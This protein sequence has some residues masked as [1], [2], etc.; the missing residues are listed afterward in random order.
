MTRTPAFLSFLFI[1][2]QTLF[3]QTAA[4]PVA[5][6]IAQ[7]DLFES[8][9]KYDLALDAYHKADKLAHHQSANCFLKMASVERRLGDFPEALNDT[10][11]AIAAA[12]NDKE[13]AVRAYMMRAILLVGMSGKPTDK[14]LKEAEEDTRQAI[15]LGP[16]RAMAHFNLG[17]ILLK[18][19]RDSDGVAELNQALGLDFPEAT[20]VEAR[21]YIAS[22]VRAREPF[23]PDFNFMTKENQAY[24]NSSLRG[25]VVLFDFWATWCP[26]CRES[27]PTIKNV[28]KK[29]ASK[30][31]VLVGIS[32]D[33]DEDVWRTFI[34]S[35][36]MDWQEYIDLAGNLN[37]AFKIESI[38]TYIVIDKDGVIRFRQSGFGSET[39]GELDDAISK[40]LKRE[41]NPALAKAA[42]VEAAPQKEES[43]SSFATRV[44][45]SDARKDEAGGNA[46]GKDSAG[47][48]EDR[49]FGIEAGTVS[50]N[51]YKNDAL[52]MTYGFPSGWTAATSEKLHSSN[53]K[54]EASLMQQ[55]PE[56]ANTAILMPKNIFYA[57]KKGD[58]DATRLSVPCM[59]ISATP[60]RLDSI[61]LDR[62]QKMAEN[63]A[64]ASSGKL[65]QP[66]NEFT[67]KEHSFARADIERMAGGMHLYQSYVQTLAGDYLLTIEIY[68]T[69]ADE[70]RKAA[71]TLETMVIRDE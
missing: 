5:Q 14:K 58:G 57:S 59:R 61:S 28:K 60:S 69:S 20:A 8:K 26:P 46:G 16:K 52:D 37:E 11:K 55:H 51:R 71:T 38:P 45:E 22:P 1:F 19:E 47:N 6:A 66:A 17:T 70:L 63:M 53:V 2:A 24:N 67:V 30:G 56:L 65:L 29:F 15:A 25:K 43:H 34:E 42:A 48:R 62:F 31:L 44:E 54:A 36:Q 21:K 49:P 32:S 7:G 13:T 39:E 23:A 10:K 18:Q 64:T 33:D 27:V 50:G 41:S 68:A 4:D 3:A 35:K 9:H 40:A 12:G